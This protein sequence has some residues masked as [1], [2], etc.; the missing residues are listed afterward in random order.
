MEFHSAMGNV[1]IRVFSQL[2]ISILLT[3]VEYF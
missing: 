2:T 3:L 1:E